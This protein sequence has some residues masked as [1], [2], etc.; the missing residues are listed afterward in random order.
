LCLT[1]HSIAIRL[2]DPSGDPGKIRCLRDLV[3]PWGSIYERE[4]TCVMPP[5]FGFR[6]RESSFG[7]VGRGGRK[8][9]GI[10]GAGEDK[11]LTGLF[12]SPGSEIV[13]ARGTRGVP[14]QPAS[15]KGLLNALHA[16]DVLASVRERVSLQPTP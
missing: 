6:F 12:Q 1:S 3:L 5:H 14:Q 15:Q 10:Q 9:G 7:E 8:A 16:A 4:E 11:L 13:L 2:G